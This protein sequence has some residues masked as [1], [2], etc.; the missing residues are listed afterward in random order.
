MKNNHTT[1][2]ASIRIAT[3][4][5]YFLLIILSSVDSSVM[6]SSELPVSM[7]RVDEKR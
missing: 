1:I 6:F 2:N 3:M 4:M 5:T 7:N